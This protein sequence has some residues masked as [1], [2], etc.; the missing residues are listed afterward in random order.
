[1]PLLLYY[2]TGYTSEKRWGL[3]CDVYYCKIIVYKVNVT[4]TLEAYSPEDL[5][6]VQIEVSSGHN[7]SHLWKDLF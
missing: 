2:T 6:N 3:G 7:T 1:M 5:G 4:M